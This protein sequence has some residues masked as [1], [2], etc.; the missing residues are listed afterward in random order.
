MDPEKMAV[1]P[2]EVVNKSESDCE[3]SSA[4]SGETQTSS[5]VQ[6]KAKHPRTN[7]WCL[8]FTS[9]WVVADSVKQDENVV[10]P[11]VPSI[12]DSL[13]DSEDEG[14][15]G[16]AYFLALSC[17]QMAWSQV[18]KVFP[19][20]PVFFGA[21]LVF[22]LGA[23]VG[24]LAPNSA[25]VIVGRAISG[26][27]I[28][29]T[30]VGALIIVSYIVPL[31]FRPLMGAFFSVLIGSTQNGGSVLGGV[32]TS[33]LSWRWCFW[34]N[35]PLGGLS[36]FLG[37]VGSSI[38]SPESRRGGK[39]VKELVRGFD[40]L[41][42]C[43]W[44]LAVICLTLILQFGGGRF[45]WT[46]GTLVALYVVTAVLFAAF[47]LVEKRGG[48][49]SLVPGRIIKQR[50]LACSALYILL[51]QAAKSQLTY[52]LPIYFQAVL[53]DS[54]MQS[55][56]H[57]LPNFVANTLF[58]ILSGMGISWVGYYTP[59]MLVGSSIGLAGS[60]LLSTLSVTSTTPQWAS[61]QVLAAV[62]IAIGYNGPQMAAQTVFQD[63]RDTPTA[64]TIITTCQDLGGSLG[65]S[66]GN[67]I[68]V[69]MVQ[70]QL[71]QLLPDLSTAQISN[72]GL[73]GLK[74]LVAPEQ[75]YLVVEAY[76]YAIRVVFYGTTALIATT[77]FLACFVEWKSVKE[78][79]KN[80]LSDDQETAEQ[81]KS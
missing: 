74:N 78:K 73:T 23:L 42:L 1:P 24:A 33:M 71:Q 58:Q 27:G 6:A 2:T 34:I 61:Y 62:G 32:L 81:Y 63:P 11:A 53:D 65:T 25:G 43:I 46:S 45:S 3:A 19:A 54:A 66:I 14:W 9:V 12:T 47:G 13:G 52:Y 39:T 28:S 16:T 59:F 17:C 69:D 79:A 50:S 18:Y 41:G 76:A 57:T 31:S 5:V 26:A 40:A 80:T 36:V 8:Y 56:V 68:L 55:S 30:F 10:A 4:T 20:K 67:A 64:L 51:M 35:L 44:S 15:Y 77:L 70:Q 7:T 29:G 75:A 60:A 22:E 48:E 37:L 38:T 21:F 49:R 72:G